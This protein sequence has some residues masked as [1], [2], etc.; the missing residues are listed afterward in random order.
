MQQ[1]ITSDLLSNMIQLIPESVKTT[2]NY[3]QIYKH[4]KHRLP[5]QM[6]DK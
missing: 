1:E 3:N 2:H 5:I 6:I 4:F